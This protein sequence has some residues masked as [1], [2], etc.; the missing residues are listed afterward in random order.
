VGLTSSSGAVVCVKSAISFTASGA[1]TYVWSAS[2]LTGSVISITTSSI[3][4]TYT[5]GVIG[6]ATNGC[7]RTATISRVV[8]ACVGIENVTENANTISIYPNPFS[9][10]LKISG[11][12]GQL[13]IYNAIGQL[14]WKQG[15]TAN[16]TVH[17]SE[18]AKGIYVL[19]LYNTEKKLI[20]TSKAIKN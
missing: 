18:F 17:T 11:L 10:E 16:E 3:A 4:G 19:K 1:G 7:V 5:F 9:S 8:D 2:A 15:L 14:V 13:E 6:T 12:D 20:Q